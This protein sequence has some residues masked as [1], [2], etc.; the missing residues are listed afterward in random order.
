MTIKTKTEEQELTLG[1]N[2]RGSE[3]V[4]LVC[5]FGIKKYTGDRSGIK[6]QGKGRD[7]FGKSR[8]KMIV[9]TQIAFCV[10]LDLFYLLQI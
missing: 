1:N 4:R 6:D 2:G 10:G 5:V 3:E 8:I 7:L 9:F